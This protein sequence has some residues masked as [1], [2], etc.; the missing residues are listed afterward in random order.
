M[1]WSR[2]KSILIISL[3]ILNLILF[4]EIYGENKIDESRLLERENF[5]KVSELLLNKS[6]DVK[7]EFDSFSYPKKAQLL[8]IDYE[9]YK[10]ETLARKFLGLDYDIFEGVAINDD[11]AVKVIDNIA[12]EYYL[13]SELDDEN[14]CTEQQA[15]KISNDFLKRYDYLEGATLLSVT[16][17]GEFFVL[18]Y[19]QFYDSSYIDETYMIVEIYDDKVV[20]FARK[21]I[22][23]VT[24]KNVSVEVVPPSLALYRV[25]EDIDNRKADVTSVITKMELGYRLEDDI[26]FSK[27]K[28]GDVFPYWRITFSDDKIIYVE[29][30]K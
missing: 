8:A 10:L 5:K 17:K 18:K 3:V 1:D 13:T 21:W 23:N 20:K 2:I 25:I 22:E 7:C 11:K 30:F 9:E 12:L 16:K 27:I 26:I 14:D 19:N 28:S 4:Y 15:I 29:A 24:R 6:I